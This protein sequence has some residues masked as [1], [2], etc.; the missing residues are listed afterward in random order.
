MSLTVK[1]RWRIVFLCTDR[2][3]PKLSEH[4][5]A[6][7]VHCSV[8]TVNHWLETF[9]ST[10]DVIDKPGRGGK[11]KTSQSED[12]KILKAA[13]SSPSASSIQLSRS[14]EERGVNVSSS[15]VRRRLHEAG[16]VY[17]SPLPKPLLKEDHRKSRLKYARQNLRR[18]WT[19]VIFTDE[20]TFHLFTAPRKV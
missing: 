2:L 1:Q 20:T 17:G 9:R 16:Y 15:T 3:G 12:E 7:E 5:A 4:A 11:R 14:L 10:G 8:S 6:K 19:R 13:E 18:N